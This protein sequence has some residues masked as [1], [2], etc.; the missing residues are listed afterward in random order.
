MKGGNMRSVLDDTDLYTFDIFNREGYYLYRTQLPFVPE[1]IRDG[2][3]YDINRSEE[4]EI[5]QIKRY[6]I[7]NWASLKDGI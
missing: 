2:Y 3:L 6:R 1:I 5:T 7:D 4:T